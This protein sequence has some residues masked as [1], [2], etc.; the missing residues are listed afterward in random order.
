MGKVRK[1]RIE[2][3]YD[4]DACVYIA[5]HVVRG[6]VEVQLSEPLEIRGT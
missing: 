5:G 6:T 3:E 1:F 2:F 4:D